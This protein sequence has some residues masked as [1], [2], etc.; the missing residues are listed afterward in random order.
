MP[1]Q[2]YIKQTNSC[3]VL[4]EH[5]TLKIDVGCVYLNF[6]DRYCQPSPVC[7]ITLLD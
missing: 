6:M 3:M 7:V 4:I 1:L 2:N 5:C